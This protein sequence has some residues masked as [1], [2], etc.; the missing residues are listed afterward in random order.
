MLNRKIDHSSYKTYL[1]RPFI[2]LG[3]SHW[4]IF[5]GGYPPGY[6]RAHQH[7][8][9]I[10]IISQIPQTNIGLDPDQTNGN[11]PYNQ[12][13]HPLRLHPKDVFH[14]T[15]NSGTR[16][17]TLSLWIRQF[18][19]PA[20]F[21]LKMLLIFSF[22]QLLELLLRTVRRVCPTSRLLLSSSRRSSKT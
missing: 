4:V 17:I 18:L 5:L 20:S 2:T 22:L 10:Q 3:R 21:V 6:L 12:L 7:A 15:S 1:N 8:V 19:V 13:P 11:G 16:S 9:S 14:T